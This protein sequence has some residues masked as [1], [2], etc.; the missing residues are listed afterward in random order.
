MLLIYVKK[1]FSFECVLFVNIVFFM[2][3][4]KRNETK[5]PLNL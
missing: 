2:E 3:I 5:H 4:N 1:F